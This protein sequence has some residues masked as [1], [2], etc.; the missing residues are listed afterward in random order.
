LR[1]QAEPYRKHCDL[2]FL[3]LV[4]YGIEG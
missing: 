3:T 4:R 1:D 2:Q